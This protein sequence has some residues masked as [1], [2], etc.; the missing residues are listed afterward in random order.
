MYKE[1]NP[2]L[3][4][5]CFQPNYCFLFAF[6]RL[7]KTTDPGP[8]LPSN[9]PRPDILSVGAFMVKIGW[10]VIMKLILRFSRQNNRDNTMFVNI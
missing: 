9:H 2:P 3:A 10:F 4:F 1:S 8:K 7:I 5:L 6:K